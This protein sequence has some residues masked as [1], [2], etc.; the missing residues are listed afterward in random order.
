MLTVGS[1]AIHP[2]Q[3]IG[4]GFVTEVFNREY[5]DEI[6]AIEKEEAYSFAQ[7]LTKEEGV[8]VGVSTGASLAVVSKKLN[9]IPENAIILT[10]NYDTG[11]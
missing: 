2:L 6:I 11:E 9:E 4:S 10:F 8:F 7:R 1:H 3:G 5:V